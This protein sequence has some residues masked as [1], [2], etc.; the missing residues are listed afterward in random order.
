MQAENAI[1]LWCGGQDRE[2]RV[3]VGPMLA[4]SIMGDFFS[5]LIEVKRKYAVRVVSATASRLIER[6]NAGELDLVLAPE[7]INLRQDDLYQH[8][9]FEDQ[10]AVFAGPKNRFYTRTDPISTKELAHER[11]IAIGALSGIFGTQKEVFSSIGVRRVSASINFTGDVMMA[12]EMLINT[13]VLCIMPRQLGTWSSALKDTRVLPLKAPLP[14]R[15][16]VLWC[17]RTERHRPDVLE[18]L[19][20]FERF[21]H[22]DIAPNELG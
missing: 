18:F 19:S 14:S 7:Q 13:D 1:D 4:A 12:A 8:K 11:W 3:G 22:S 2:L 10:L 9:L 15:N 17:R 16:V 20:H 5:K 21:V 6:L